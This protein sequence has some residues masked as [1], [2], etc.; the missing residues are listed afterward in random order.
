MD[1]P[2]MCCVFIIRCKFG[3]QAKWK[4]ECNFVKAVTKSWL[5]SMI[6][7]MLTSDSL[8]PTKL[9]DTKHIKVEKIGSRFNTN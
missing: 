9:D 2:L 3:F 1:D 6:V 5:L 4:S 8:V 7:L